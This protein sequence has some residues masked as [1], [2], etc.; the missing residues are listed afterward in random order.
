MR[1][2]VQGKTMTTREERK[3]WLSLIFSLLGLVLSILALWATSKHNALV[4]RQTCINEL[5]DY[6]EEIDNL[7]TKVLKSAALYSLRPDVKYLI[8][9]KKERRLFESRINRTRDNLRK[10]ECSKKLLTDL[11][12][13]LEAYSGTFSLNPAAPDQIP[14]GVHLHN[15]ESI[16][17][18]NYVQ[19]CCY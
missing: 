2:S 11:D 8:D 3:F 1:R 15:L 4:K 12:W 16:R 7:F 14:V 10:Y 13:V 19:E 6:P 17:S 9:F 5:K 18:L